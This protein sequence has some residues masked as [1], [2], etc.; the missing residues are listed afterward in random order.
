MEMIGIKSATI[1]E[2]GQITIPKDLREQEG[3][4]VGSKVA[5]ISYEDRIELKPLKQIDEE[6]S[7][8][9]CAILSESSLKKIWDTPEED[10]A[11]KD[12]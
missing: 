10:E 5:I 12:L 7:A 1:T 3:F 8:R 2:K 6:I 11:W 9:E 4:E